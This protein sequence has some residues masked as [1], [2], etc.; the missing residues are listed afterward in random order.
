MFYIIGGEPHL[1]LSPSIFLSF[2]PSLSL[3]GTC[4]DGNGANL[5][6]AWIGNARDGMKRAFAPCDKAKPCSPQEMSSSAT[7]ATTAPAPAPATLHRV[8]ATL[9]PGHATPAKGEG[10]ASV[11]G[12][13]VN[14]LLHPFLIPSSS[15]EILSSDV[16]PVG[17][18]CRQHVTWNPFLS[19]Y[20]SL[21]G[22]HKVGPQTS[23]SHC[24]LS[25][26]QP[27][28]DPLV[29]A[30]GPR[31]TQPPLPCLPPTWHHPPSRY[32]RYGGR[33]AQRTTKMRVTVISYV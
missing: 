7:P 15:R 28:G 4:A 18:Y 30:C 14:D 26:A 29:R 24:P 2:P 27:M 20:R 9:T 8:P 17:F 1:S 32:L 5:C 22:G 10:E 33:L 21:P 23:P 6:P 19:N 3:A 31:S 16:K 11:L 25:Q 13:L 12:F